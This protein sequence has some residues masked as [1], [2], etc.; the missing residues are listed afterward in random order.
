MI[1]RVSQVGAN[2]DIFIFLD[3]GYY[4]GYGGYGGKFCWT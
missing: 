3:G 2:I 1:F 4:G